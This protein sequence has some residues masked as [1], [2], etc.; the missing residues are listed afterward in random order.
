MS[1]V[2]SGGV[3]TSVNGSPSSGPVNIT[4]QKANFNVT[5]TVFESNGTTPAGNTGVSASSPGVSCCTGT[6]SDQNGNY[7]FALADGTWN[8]SANPPMGDSVDAPTSITVVVSGGVV[9]SVNGSPSSGPVNIT[10]QKANLTGTVYESNGTTPAGNT[11]VSAGNPGVFCCTSTNTNQNGNYAFALADGTWSISANPPMG[12]SADA[13][14]SVS[15]VVS[16][17]VVTSVNGS[18]SSGPVN[19]TLQT[20]NLTGT[21]TK[22]AAAGGGAA[23]NSGVSAEEQGVPNNTYTSTDMNGHYGAHLGDGT[24]VVTASPPMSDS[25]DASTSVS[26]TV[27][28]GVVTSCAGTAC[29]G[30][31]PAVNITLQVPGSISGTVTDYTAST[32]LQGI[33][34]TAFPVG[35]GGFVGTADTGTGGTYSIG[36]L[37]PGNYDV[38]FGPSGM[39]PGGSAGNYPGQYYKGVSSQSAATPVTVSSGAITPNIDA[40]MGSPFP[41]APP[42]GTVS[43]ASGTSIDPSGSAMATNNG[44]TVEAG[45]QGAFTVSQYGSDPVGAPGFSTPGGFLDVAVASGSNF[46]SVTI[47]DCNLNGATSLQWWT[48]SAW[49]AVSPTT[50]PTGNPPCLTA[51]L[52]STSTPTVAELA[53]TVFAAAVTTVPTVTTIA[54]TSGAPIVQYGSS[55]T[56][57]AKVTVSSGSA[58]PNGNVTFYDGTTAISGP[59]AV[60]GGVATFT[61]TTLGAGTHSINAAY[62][63]DV[64]TQASSSSSI[65]E[66]VTK[67]ATWTGVTASPNRTT[68]GQAVTVTATVAPSLGHGT[69]TFY[70]GFKAISGPLS[71][72]AGVATFKTSGLGAG[73]HLISAAYSGD[74]NTNPSSGMTV[75][76]VSKRSS[77]TTLTSSANPSKA[78]TSLTLTATV[79]PPNAT[80]TV[81]FNDG[82]REVGSCILNGGKCSWSTTKLSK[83]THAM[84]AVYVG[85]GQTFGSTSPVLRQVIS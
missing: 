36:K 40:A 72:N 51:T 33:C 22:S 54:R 65:R 47:T 29:S 8:I 34:V 58:T 23:Q 83:C 13:Q 74:A 18:P 50:G 14:T 2:V 10:L 15:V 11:G 49:E 4:L 26:V 75:E 82:A 67:R 9:T 20:A 44:T 59:V 80:G 7:A 31:L 52:S 28:G 6:N 61:T 45:G 32:D 70:D 64:G 84:T 19:I 62:S 16:G 85:D 55:L 42:S 21:V 48:G 5:G 43:S 76:V 79:V 24:W 30:T 63:G 41:P 78:G 73:T 39:C 38:E 17:G 37:A 12:D 56:F 60:S 27:S 81:M 3:V 35:G 77:A 25:T 53:G 1:V 69:V 46:S 66:V 71:L 68:V 57:T